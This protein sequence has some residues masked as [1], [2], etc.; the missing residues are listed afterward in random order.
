MYPATFTELLLG[1]GPMGKVVT[2][3]SP[4]PQ[5][6]RDNPVLFSQGSQSIARDR[7]SDRGIRP[8]MEECRGLQRPKGDH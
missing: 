6:D 4:Y 7:E 5:G 8:V 1:A 3:W 2:R